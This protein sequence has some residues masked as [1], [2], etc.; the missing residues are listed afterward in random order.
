MPNI[1]SAVKRAKTSAIANLRNRGVKSEV[2]SNQKKVLE[3]IQAGDKAVAGTANSAYASRLD[4]AVKK[5]VLKKNNAD[6]KKSRMA[7]AIGKM[8]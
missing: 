2:L 4:K 5:G 8:V 3:A 1:K 7:L 6:R